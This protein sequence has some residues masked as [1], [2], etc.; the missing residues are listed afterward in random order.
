MHKSNNMHA[1]STPGSV[2]YW[3]SNTGLCIKETN[4]K[5]P[6]KIINPFPKLFLG[7]RRK[8]RYIHPLE[9][10]TMFRK[11]DGDEM[12]HDRKECRG[13]QISG[14]TAGEVTLPGSEAWRA[15]P[16]LRAPQGHRA[17]GHC[18]AD[19]KD[20][21]GHAPTDR[22]RQGHAR[23]HRDG[24]GHARTDT[25]EA[26]TPRLLPAWPPP[27]RV[28]AYAAP[29]TQLPGRPRRRPRPGTASSGPR[30]RRGA[31]V[32]PGRPAGSPRC[33][34]LGG[35]GRTAAA[36]LRATRPLSAAD[37]ERDA[38]MMLN[39]ATGRRR[40]RRAKPPPLGQETRRQGRNEAEGRGV[41]KG[42]QRTGA[43]ER[44]WGGEP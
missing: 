23:T 26:S 39:A 5:V 13:V 20:G 31:A 1:S 8:N 36:P 41:G 35:G 37:I 44:G 4:N 34:Y 43:R 14:M 42:G 12:Q 9:K 2:T 22:N 25:E 21:Q 11:R 24:Q 7:N 15:E 29:P 6:P 18:E 32:P 19:S 27:T 10:V 16:D 40:R 17:G 33:R 3:T 28:G 30:G 38:A